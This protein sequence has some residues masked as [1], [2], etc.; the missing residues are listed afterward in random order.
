MKET[1]WKAGINPYMT[2]VLDGHE[3]KAIYLEG[4]DPAYIVAWANAFNEDGEL[5]VD[6][7]IDRALLIAAAPEMFEALK[8]IANMSPGEYESD[9]E[10]AHTITVSCY[11]CDEMISI[12]Q[13]ILD[14]LDGLE[15]CHQEEDHA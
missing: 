6:K 11:N 3:G 5:A 15:M 13:E 7:A 8:K 2:D 1:K 4:S 14:K 12:A 9:T 10:T